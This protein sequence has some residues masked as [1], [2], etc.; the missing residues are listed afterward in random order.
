MSAKRDSG[1]LHLPVIEE[2]KS[3]LRSD[4]KRVEIVTA[5]VKGR[6]LTWRRVLWAVLIAFAAALPFVHIG[7][8][9]ALFLDVPA[10]RFFL[11]GFS[12]NAQDAWLLFFALTALGF[13]LVV[14]TTVLGRVW[15]GWTC[16]QTVLLEGLFRPVERWIEGPRTAH[17]KRDAGPWT[18]G[19]V[20]RK[21]AKHTA[22][23]GLAWLCAHVLV[24]YF[25]SLPSLGTMILEGPLAHPEAFAWSIAFALA[26]YLD[27][28]WF[29]EQLCL[30]VCPYG[31]L[32][33]MLTDDDSLTVGYDVSRGEPRG[34]RKKGEDK[35]LGD[36]VDCNR[37]VVVCPTGIDIRN[38]LQVDCIGCTQCIDA[39]DEVMD[40]VEKPRGL[41]RYD[42]LRGLR[43]EK[44]RWWRPRLALYAVLGVIGCV[45]LAFAVSSHSPFEANLLRTPG[46]LFVRD[47]ES[48]R[49]SLELHLMNKQDAEATFTI[50][51]VEQPEGAEVVIASPETPVEA[52]GSRRVPI[53]VRLPASELTQGAE[54]TLRVSAS[55]TDARE[56]VTI[57]I[58]GPYRAER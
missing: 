33:S 20:L 14:V 39:C 41:I 53:V 16:P 22:F 31:R 56:E 44:R 1:R 8:R 57:P 19:R 10:R 48:I 5:D 51:I 58:L 2:R 29:R 46:A 47:G 52:L 50:A 13:G 25:A 35:E 43:G 9:P 54:L 45:A 28:A 6:F 26:I 34:H 15:C 49:N 23:I 55:G 42:S 38:G 4:G 36:C 32:Q 37:C 18:S 21:I 40:R 12:M 3:S 11:F 27:M 24:A 30:V 7:G 17:M